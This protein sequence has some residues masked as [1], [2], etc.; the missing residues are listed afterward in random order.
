MVATR[1][2]I[3]LEE[4]PEIAAAARESQTSGEPIDLRMDGKTIAVLEPS[5][6]WK[7]GDSREM[8]TADIAEFMKTE[9]SWK[10][11]IDAE[12]FLANN[13]KSRRISTRS[14]VTVEIPD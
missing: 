10:D 3:N 1:R 2:H 8:T 5:S 13:E 6:A 12:Q 4:I 11:H 9:G 7:P 14:E